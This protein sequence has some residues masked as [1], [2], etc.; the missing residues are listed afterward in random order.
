MAFS[1]QTLTTVIK[2]VSSSSDCHCQH[3]F[4]AL[5]YSLKPYLLKMSSMQNQMW[6]LISLDLTVPLTDIHRIKRQATF[7]LAFPVPLLIYFATL[8]SCFY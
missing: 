8:I 4:C 6:R 3:Q 5:K 2:D 7:V 1:T